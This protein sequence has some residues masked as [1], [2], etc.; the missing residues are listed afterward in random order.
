MRRITNK[1]LSGGAWVS[2]GACSYWEGRSMK[3]ILADMSERYYEQMRLME[4][5]QY[6]GLVVMGAPTKKKAR[7]LYRTIKKAW[8]QVS[9]LYNTMDEL[10]EIV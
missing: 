1:G 9:R 3:R 10:E 6:D 2:S 4:K 7:K 5:G 8:K